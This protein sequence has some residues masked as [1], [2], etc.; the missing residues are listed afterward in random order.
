MKKGQLLNKYPALFTYLY[1]IGLQWGRALYQ[2]FK[3]ASS[4]FI[5]R[6]MK[7]DRGWDVRYKYASRPLS[8]FIHLPMKMELIEG[9]ETSA[10]STLTPGNYPK[11]NISH[12]EH[13][14]SLKSRKVF[15]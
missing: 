10:I 13:G 15:V 7:Y 11:E 4:I 6:W 5:G 8:Y 14:E 3:K 1:K 9:S 12:I 2:L